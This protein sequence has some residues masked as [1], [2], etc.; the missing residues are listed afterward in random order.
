[1]LNRG[2]FNTKNNVNNYYSIFPLK[3]LLIYE[4]YS[5]GTITTTQARLLR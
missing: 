4:Q 1:M 5:E 2:I 3:R